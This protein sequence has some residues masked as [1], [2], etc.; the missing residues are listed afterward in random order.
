MWNISKGITFPLWKQK[1]LLKSLHVFTSSE[2]NHYVIIIRYPCKDSTYLSRCLSFIFIILIP[3]TVNPSILS[4]YSLHVSCISYPRFSSSNTNGLTSHR[5]TQSLV[6]RYYILISWHQYTII[7]TISSLKYYRKSL[8]GISRVAGRED[9]PRLKEVSTER[10]ERF[11]NR[12]GSGLGAVWSNILTYY[13]LRLPLPSFEE[14]II[15]ICWSCIIWL[16]SYGYSPHI[17]GNYAVQLEILALCCSK[18]CLKGRS[19]ENN[20]IHQI[21][22]ILFRRGFCTALY[23]SV[24]QCSKGWSCE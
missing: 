6:S 22:V 8:P 16:Q 15:K 10:G 11:H 3:N 24:Q 14:K 23:C 20:F 21:H 18:H 7:T 4:G 1:I 5:R 12:G 17:L 19:Y 9:P 2:E 13:P